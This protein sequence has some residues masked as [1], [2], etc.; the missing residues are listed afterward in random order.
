MIVK[1]EKNLNLQIRDTTDECTA[2]N[3]VMVGI[4][5]H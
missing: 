5:K 2:L 3:S 1:K 4:Y